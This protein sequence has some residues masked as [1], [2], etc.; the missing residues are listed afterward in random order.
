MRIR[1]LRNATLV[2]SIGPHRLLVDPMLGAAG[3]MPGFRMIGGTGRRNPTVEL[4]AGAPA[5]LDD[6]TGALVTHEHPDHLDGAGRRFLRERGLPVWASPV[7][8]ASL[9]AKGLDARALDGL[10][11]DVEIVPARHGRGLVGWLMGPVAGVYLAHEGEPSVLL[12]SDAVLCDA[13]LDAIE[14]LRPEVIVAPAGAANF[15]VG[16][17]ILFSLDELVTLVRRA[18]GVVV[19]NHLEAL[20]HCPT[21]REALRARMERE[22]LRA[23]VRIP[24]D[25]EELVLARERVEERPRVRP[26]A[27][28]GGLQKWV[29]ARLSG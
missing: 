23:K 20:D 25:G 1:Q 5:W 4:P 2:L 3:S 28:A 9:R 26:V 8:V 29:A 10:G 24:D 17:D 7:D 22:G 12:T 6:L 13:L 21:T 16:G 19:L 27:P 14:R 15:G 11:I 18:P